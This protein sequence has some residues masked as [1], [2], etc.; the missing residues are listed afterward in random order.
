[1]LLT[2]DW[3]SCARKLPSQH[4][5]DKLICFEELSQTTKELAQDNLPSGQNLNHESPEYEERVLRILPGLRCSE[6]EMWNCV[7]I[8][9]QFSP[10]HVG[11]LHPHISRVRPNYVTGKLV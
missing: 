11:E 6:E 7:F 3:K 9:Q 2:M 4:N 10:T 8:L 5:L 1:M